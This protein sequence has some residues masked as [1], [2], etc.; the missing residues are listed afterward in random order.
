MD[1]ENV[2]QN[3]YSSKELN[4]EYDIKICTRKGTTPMVS[5]PLLK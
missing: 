2:K 3:E 4:K 1:F 5:R